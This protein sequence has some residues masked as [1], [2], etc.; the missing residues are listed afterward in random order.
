M[1]DVGWCLALPGLVLADVARTLSSRDT[2]CWSCL[3]DMRCQNRQV[4]GHMLPPRLPLRSHA[5]R[6]AI[7][8]TLSASA[9]LTFFHFFRT[10]CGRKNCHYGCQVHSCQGRAGPLTRG[11]G[12]DSPMRCQGR[13]TLCAVSWLALA[14]PS[15]WPSPRPCASWLPGPSL[16]PWPLPRP[17][18]PRPR[19]GCVS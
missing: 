13:I 18:R 1:L 17:H 5:A 9:E 3:K 4:Q 14:C 16:P 11:R 12:A 6:S 19:G 8:R 7:S 2:C 15:P 10:G